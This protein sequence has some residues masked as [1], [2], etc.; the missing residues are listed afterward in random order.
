MTVEASPDAIGLKIGVI[1]DVADKMT[2]LDK[3]LASTSKKGGT[4]FYERFKCRQE[5]VMTITE[6]S[7]DTVVASGGNCAYY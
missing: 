6:I 3:T 7:G 4:L 1:Y 2:F 5:S